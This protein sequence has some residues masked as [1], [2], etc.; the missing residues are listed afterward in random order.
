MTRRSEDL[1]YRLYRIYV[2][3]GLA[4]L[5]LYI[6]SLLLTSDVGRAARHTLVA[7]PVLLWV[8]GV[9][10]YWWWVFLVKETRATEASCRH[11][12]QSTPPLRALRNWTTLHAAMAAY[13]GDVDA[14]LQAARAARRPVIIW[15]GTMNLLILWILGGFW[16]YFRDDS[17]GT[18]MGAWIGGVL[19]IMV[20]FAVVIPWL[21]SRASAGG[22]IAHLAPLGLSPAGPSPLEPPEPRIPGHG[23]PVRH[24]G[25]RV[26]HGSRRGRPVHVETIGWRCYTF[27]GAAM[28]PF[29]IHS[30]AGKLVAGEGAPEAVT[31][32]LKGLRKAKRWRGIQVTGGPDGIGIERESRGWNMWLYD[33]WLI[34]RVLESSTQERA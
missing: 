13:G 34:E 15:Y 17:P 12:P 19:V 1:D 9:L 22:E 23:Y 29:E 21:L 8:L 10:A 30:R 16:V 33:L 25:A 27:V 26:I 31:R 2:W 5:V 20:L 6:V 14:I 32:A 11:R 3:A 4:A 18:R 7:V 28:P 24:D